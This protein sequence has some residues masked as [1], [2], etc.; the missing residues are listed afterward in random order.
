MD[1]IRSMCKWGHRSPGGPAQL[2]V[3]VFTGLGDSEKF[4]VC[5]SLLA[6]AA[7]WKTELSDLDSLGWNF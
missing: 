5:V 6:D 4:E 2:Y 3:S 7:A 1:P